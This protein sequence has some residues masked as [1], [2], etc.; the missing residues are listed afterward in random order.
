M[1]LQAMMEMDNIQRQA[2]DLN[3]IILLMSTYESLMQLKN[4]VRLIQQSIDSLLWIHRSP[5]IQTALADMLAVASSSSEDEM[6]LPPTPSSINS[7]AA[8]PIGDQEM[9]TIGS[10]ERIYT[11]VF[12]GNEKD[13]PSD[14]IHI[15]K[16]QLVQ[17]VARRSKTKQEAKKCPNCDT[18]FVTTNKNWIYN[19]RK[20][21]NGYCLAVKESKTNASESTGSSLMDNQE[22]IQVEQSHSVSKKSKT[23]SGSYKLPRL[24]PAPNQSLMALMSIQEVIP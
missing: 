7:A 8:V 5:S 21:L 2:K 10:Q 13:C 23:C 22:G 4:Q 1:E 18:S 6:D 17:K 24:T 14:S 15:S 9:E 20:H 19:L 11:D 3:S 12:K 16:I